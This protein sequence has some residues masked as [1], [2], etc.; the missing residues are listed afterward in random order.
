[1][2]G[3]MH[4]PEIELNRRRELSFR[5]PAALGG[6]RNLLCFAFH[7]KFAVRAFKPQARPGTPS[8]LVFAKGGTWLFSFEISGLLSD[9]FL[10]A[11]HGSQQFASHRSP[12]PRGALI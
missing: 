4:I 9:F 6:T 7:L 10:A 1:M 12:F 2:T 5:D 11:R 8:L 3:V